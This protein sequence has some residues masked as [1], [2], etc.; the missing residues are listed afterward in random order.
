VSSNISLLSL[1]SQVPYYVNFSPVQV[2]SYYTY[3]NITN[4]GLRVNPTGKHIVYENGQ[5]G[6]PASFNGIGLG[7]VAVV[8]IHT[9]NGWLNFTVCFVSPQPAWYAR[10]GPGNGIGIM[11]ENESDGGT[12]MA[13]VVYWYS[14]SM[15]CWEINYEVFEQNPFSQWSGYPLTWSSSPI[16]SGNSSIFDYWA[17]NL[18]FTFRYAVQFQE[19]QPIKLYV[20]VLNFSDGQWIPIINGATIVPANLVPDS[21]IIIVPGYFY[22][23]YLRYALVYDITSTV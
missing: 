17:P 3:Q 13:L 6:M 16:Y 22:Q 14:T 7:S 2:T 21:N 1:E 5:N 20:W 19:G 12:W 9:G 15:N 4:W 8:P 11:F 10:P 23:F 18:N